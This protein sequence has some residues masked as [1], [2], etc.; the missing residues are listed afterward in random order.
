MSASGLKVGQKY[1]VKDAQNFLGDPIASGTYE[2][3]EV[4]LPMTGR[5][6]AVPVGKVLHEPVHTAPEFG[7]FV[8]LPEAGGPTP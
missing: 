7:V 5:V 4:E 8:V 6:H 1:Q 3:R 2:G